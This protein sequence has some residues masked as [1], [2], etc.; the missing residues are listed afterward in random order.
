MAGEE[1]KGRFGSVGQRHLRG[2]KAT[3]RRYDYPAALCDPDQAA[4]TLAA[5]AIW[6]LS[7]SGRVVICLIVLL[8]EMGGKTVKE[9]V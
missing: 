2:R 3:L 5:F 6:S 1:N 9:R 4:T 7:E 8:T